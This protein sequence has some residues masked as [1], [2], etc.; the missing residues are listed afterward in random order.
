MIHVLKLWLIKLKKD[1]KYK[2]IKEVNIGLYSKLLK[3]KK[4]NK[5]KVKINNDLLRM[6]LFIFTN[7]FILSN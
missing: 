1:K 2:E 5:Y 4:I 7:L 6:Y 3:Q